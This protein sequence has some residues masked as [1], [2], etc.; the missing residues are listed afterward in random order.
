LSGLNLKKKRVLKA[1]RTLLLDFTKREWL[2][3][4]LWSG[5]GVI[6]S[7]L[8]RLTL[9]D[10]SFQGFVSSR[11][12]PTAKILDN[13]HLY[14][15]YLLATAAAVFVGII[16]RIPVF[17]GRGLRSWWAGVTSGL[18]F[19]SCT[20]A[21]AAFTFGSASAPH[22]MA[23]AFAHIFVSCTCSF[24]LYL[25]ARIHAEK[26]PLE[27]ELR[28]SSRATSPMMTQWGES[29]D[30]IRTWGEDAIGRASLVDSMSVKLMISKSPV[31]ALFGELGCGK[32]STLNL[33]RE[34][35][36][37]KAIVVV[38]STWLPGSQETFTSYLLSDIANECQK[39]YVVP[40]LR[41]SAQRLGRALGQN[42]PFLRNYL[43]LL[44]GTTQ[45]DDIENLHAAL[46]RLRGR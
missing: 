30:P 8:V 27:D 4:F 18:A 15:P 2:L 32:T 1:W 14:F 9:W 23:V 11:Y 41:K 45:R 34:H 26:T 10:H 36:G 40:G 6:V 7:G 46:A 28:V 3:V 17:L 42:V 31:L 37:N 39:H 25:I 44:P 5:L 43:E 12:I 33:L 13:P 19:L 38:F 16:L 35:L 21:F 29:D 20:S 24:A 22:R